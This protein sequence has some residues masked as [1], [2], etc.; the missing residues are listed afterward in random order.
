MNI[1][2][3]HAIGVTLLLIFLTACSVQRHKTVPAEAGRIET[4][5][6]DRVPPVT[7]KE[8]INMLLEQ[9]PPH[10]ALA[11][12]HQMVENGVPES[13]LSSEYLKALQGVLK[14]AEKLM[15]KGVYSEAGNSFKA[16]LDLYPREAELIEMVPLSIEQIKAR[17]DNCADQLM[18]DGLLAYRTG[19]LKTAIGTWEKIL[20]FQPQ[21]EASQKAIHT[22]A[23]QLNNLKTLEQKQ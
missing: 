10:V 14:H 19:D 6:I 5:M 23:L 15:A 12:I 20:S 17:I 7:P 11:T 1:Q 21:H 18:E 16:A 9:Q 8:E 13:T 2:F 4:K 3:N 22:A